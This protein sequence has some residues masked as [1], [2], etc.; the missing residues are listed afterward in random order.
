MYRLIF[1]NIN[2]VIKPSKQ[3][4]NGLIFFIQDSLPTTDLQA[5]R[6]QCRAYWQTLG[7]LVMKGLIGGEA[8]LV[9]R[10]PLPSNARLT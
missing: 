10:R 3:P 8:M 5:T 9:A 1:C 7:W 2:S 6:I 4:D